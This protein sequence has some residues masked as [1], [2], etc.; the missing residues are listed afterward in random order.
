MIVSYQKTQLQPQL[1]PHDSIIIQYHTRTFLSD[2]NSGCRSISPGTHSHQPHESHTP[3]YAQS[4]INHPAAVVIMFK[5]HTTRRTIM[6]R[7]P[8][9]PANKSIKIRILLRNSSEISYPKPPIPLPTAKP[10]LR[11][12]RITAQSFPVANK[13]R[14]TNHFQRLPTIGSTNGSLFRN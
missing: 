12:V 6:R 7:T 2:D 10:S 3:M 14:S 9:M 13:S 5:R 11:P 4:I 8:R 1:L